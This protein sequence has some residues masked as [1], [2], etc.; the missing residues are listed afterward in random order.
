MKS[1]FHRFA[2]ML[3]A[4]FVLAPLT[5]QAVPSFARQTG[6]QCIAC[7]TE[8][9]ELTSFGRQ[10]KL[11]GYTLSTGQTDLPPIAFMLL[12]SFTN[13]QQGQAG[14]AATRFNDNNNIAMTQMSMF[15]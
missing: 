12:P 5:C 1:Y 4:G 3:V 6:L 13:T 7:H 11:T 10:F 14:G 8:F 15:Y 2:L 9:P